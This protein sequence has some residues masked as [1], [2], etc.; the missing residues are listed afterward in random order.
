MI[1]DPKQEE[2]NQEEEDLEIEIDEEGHTESPS[3]EQPAPEP[4]TPQTETDE[5]PIEED[6]SDESKDEEESDDK[7]VYG[8]RAEKR[9][10]RLVKQRKELQEQLEKL[11]TEKVNFEKERTELIGRSAE[12][13]LEAVKQY[14]NRL[15]AQEKEV[16]ATLRDAKT[17][18][19]IEKEIEATDKLAS[20]KAESLIVKQYE[21]KANRTSTAKEQVSSD[22]VK[23][24]ES[25][26]VPDRRA[27]QWQKRNSWFGGNDQ[28]QKI[29][30]Q[31]AMVIHKELIDEGV[32]PD[33]DPDEY[34]SELDA[35]IRTE[36]PDKFKNTASA[37]KVQVV[38]GGTRTSPS[39]KQKVTLTK[40]EVDTANKLGVSL[41]EYAKQ[42]MRRD[43]AA[44]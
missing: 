23:Q 20:I 29:M 27:V 6:E 17:N 33:A 9:I 40:S 44:G 7:K 22:E 4:E 41:Q 13:E 15:K 10:K 5:D 11:Q 28:S 16:L 18:N 24:S 34:Y 19:D 39:G 38:A 30:T 2:L 42:K 31:A 21:D 26:R 35:R 25:E 1:E 37:K 3:E 43:Q 36:F 8:K 12:S 32:Y 14:G